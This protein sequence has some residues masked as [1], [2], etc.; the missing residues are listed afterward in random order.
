LTVASSQSVLGSG[1][2]YVVRVNFPTFDLYHFIFTAATGAVW[3]G[4]R[5]RQSAG[6]AN[7]FSRAK[8][9]AK[10]KPGLKVAVSDRSRNTEWTVT[11]TE[12]QVN[13]WVD[14]IRTWKA[15]AVAAAVV[16]SAAAATTNKTTGYVKLTA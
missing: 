12:L 10:L 15:R 2:R 11:P 6:L 16:A 14:Q 13:R 1:R 5:A 4:Q 8:A 7:G 9:R 3:N